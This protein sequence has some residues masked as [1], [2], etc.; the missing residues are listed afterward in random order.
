MTDQSN[1]AARTPSPTSRLRVPRSSNA[2]R[3]VPTDARPTQ[4]A[5]AQ[6]QAAAVNQRASLLYVRAG[7]TAQG[8]VQ[9]MGAGVVGGRAFAFIRVNGQAHFLALKHF[10]PGDFNFMHQ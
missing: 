9:Q 7:H 4:A 3:S 8:R 6:R 5:W 2:R 1:P 10:A